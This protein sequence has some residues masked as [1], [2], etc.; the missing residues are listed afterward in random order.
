M[1][2]V[3]RIIKLRQVLALE[4]HSTTQNSMSAED[5]QWEKVVVGF[6]FF[7]HHFV[8]SNQEG[9]TEGDEGSFESTKHAYRMPRIL[10]PMHMR[11][12]LVCFR[13]SF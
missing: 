10:F 9:E 1:V 4:L 5:K 12:A 11:F 2:V 3:H 13:L 8:K 7:L 6:L